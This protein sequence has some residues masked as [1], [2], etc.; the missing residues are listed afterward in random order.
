L[1]YS[2]FVI[3]LQPSILA[4]KKELTTQQALPFVHW[5]GKVLKEIGLQNILVLSA[6]VESQSILNSRL[7]N[8]VALA[9]VLLVAFVAPVLAVDYN[10]GVSVGQYVKYGNFY[11]I[12]LRSVFDWEKVEVIAVSGK[13]VTLLTTG[14]FKNGTA[15][16]GLGITIHNLETGATNETHADLKSIMAANL[17]EGDA[18]PPGTLV[19]NKTE[20]RTYLGVSR[21]VNVLTEEISTDVATARVTAVYDKASGMALEWENWFSVHATGLQ[22]A[23]YYSVT[24]TNIFEV[25]HPAAP[26]PVEAFYALG[27]VAVAIPVTTA[28][29]LRKRKLGTRNEV[30]EQKVMDL[31]YNLSGVNRGECYLADSLE[32]CLKVASDLHSRGVNVLCII[33]EDP[34][35]ITETYNLKP[36]DVVLLSSKPI[37]GFK[38]VDGLQEVAITIMKFL[39][40][41]GGAV[42]LDGLEYLISRFGFNTVYKMCQENHIGFLEAG[43][44][45][46]IPLNM[47]TLDNREKGQLLSEL[48]VL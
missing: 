35:S 18:V 3:C 44:V 42:I 23:I 4:S 5:F 36:E 26:I 8:A 34:E 19:I 20:I 41:G 28:V 21:V 11:G 1:I 9:S 39:K 37:K 33:R 14:Q 48:K 15:L 38:A 6:I 12:N 32:H 43:A 2:H 16:P 30:L 13:E 17:N 45:L 24:D 7:T 47:E 31:T 27:A 29:V 22:N 46:L 40:A 25:T 10:P